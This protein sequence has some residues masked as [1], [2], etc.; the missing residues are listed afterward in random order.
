MNI[1]LATYEDLDNIEAL[2]TH[3]TEHIEETINYAGWVKDVY[4]TRDTAKSALERSDLFMLEK[5]NNILGLVILNN[6]EDE[7][8]KDITWS[9]QAQSNEL[10]VV[11]TLAINPNFRNMGSAKAL[12]NFAKEYAM[13]NKLKTIRLDT[14]I[15]NIPAYTLYESLGYKLCGTIELKDSSTPFNEVR[16]Y[17]LIL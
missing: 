15:G 11:H 3:L 9:V 5:E 16:C 6:I 4:P 13:E 1:R 14:H 7:S 2:Y 10:L 8:Y 17:D 12:M